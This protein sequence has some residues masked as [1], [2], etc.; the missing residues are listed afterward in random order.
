[1]PR[2]NL[3]R[4]IIGPLTIFRNW[5]IELERVWLRSQVGSI[6]HGSV[7]YEGTVLAGFPRNILVGDDMQIWH[8]CF[9]AVGKHGRI[10][11]AG[12]GLLGVRCYLNASSGKIAVG[13]GVAIAPLTQ[14][15]SYSHTYSQ[16]SKVRE[17]WQIAD[18]TIEDDVLIGSAVTI[19]PGVT[20]G[21]GAIIGAGAVVVNDI[22]PYTVVAGVPAREIGRRSQ[23]GK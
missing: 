10:S 7:I 6:G 21:Q 20:I 16:D 9:L 18:V 15:Y 14:I 23:R 5:Q 3:L 19:L 13:K 17:T 2:D 4:F 11:F 22:P 1:M 12:Q 8:Q